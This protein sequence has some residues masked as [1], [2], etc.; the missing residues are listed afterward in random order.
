MGAGPAPQDKSHADCRSGRKPRVHLHHRCR[1]DR[2]IIAHRESLEATEGNP[3]WQG[4][5]RRS[6]GFEMG[7]PTPK[8]Q[9][10]LL[11]QLALPGRPRPYQEPSGIPNPPEPSTVALLARLT[12]CANRMPSSSRRA[13]GVRII[14][15][16]DFLVRVALFAHG[17]GA[18]LAQ[19]D[20]VTRAISL[21]KESIP[22]AANFI[23]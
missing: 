16:E 11:Q 15:R 3:Q 4:L 21:E 23:Q 5:S 14:V 10:E 9:A 7:S 22:R 18:I 19:A 17:R 1:A 20:S 12:S 6:G 8:R 13:E 2:G